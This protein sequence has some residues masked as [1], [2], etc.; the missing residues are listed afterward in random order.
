MNKLTADEIKALVKLLDDPNE[1]IYNQ[2]SGRLL[3]Q[4]YDVIPKLEAAWEQSFDEK[5]QSRLENLIQ[6]IQFNSA[7]NNFREWA[8]TGGEDLFEGAFLLAKHQYPELNF[9]YYHDKLETIKKDIWLE[10]N[11]NLTA[12]E[13]VRIINH[14]LF[15]IYGFSNNAANF[16]AP[17]NNYINHVL[18]TKKG[19]PITLSILYSSLAEKLNIPIYGVNLPKNFIVGYKNE[20]TESNNPKNQ[21]LFYI[22]PYNKG[23]ILG[24]K[25]IDY[26]IKQQDLKPQKEYYLP[27][28]NIE[29][30]QRLISNLIYSYDRM[31]YPD[32]IEELNQLYSILE[33]NSQI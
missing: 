32:K 11:E 4:G 26:F 7:K 5:I 2:V 6:E 18:E 33:E 17:Q 3:D 20:Y 31:G 8:M 15:K 10:I 28:S 29:T 19:N 22:N 27:C 9:E 13:K 1:E 30:I 25:E 24:K 21:M 12:L 14:I 16:Y 23:A